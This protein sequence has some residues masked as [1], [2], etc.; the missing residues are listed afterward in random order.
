MNGTKFRLML[1]ALAGSAG[2]PLTRAPEQI[3]ARAHA[4]AEA[5]M[6]ILEVERCGCTSPDGRQCGLEAMARLGFLV[7]RDASGPLNEHIAACRCSACHPSGDG[8][9]S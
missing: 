6:A 4:I 9:A 8:D 5:S 3:A 1:A 7:N 2:F